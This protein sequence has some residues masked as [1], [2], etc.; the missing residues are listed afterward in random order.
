[1]PSGGSRPGAGRKTKGT[2][3]ICIKVRP[4]DK[5]FLSDMAQEMG[6]TQGD[7]LHELINTFKEVS[8]EKGRP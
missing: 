6:V 1:M 7:V 4:E 8:K 5:Q 3:P 2:I